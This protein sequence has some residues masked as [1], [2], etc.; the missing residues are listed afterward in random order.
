MYWIEVYTLNVLD[1][2]YCIE[3]YTIWYVLVAIYCIEMYTWYVMDAIYYKEIHTWNLPGAIYNFIFSSG[4]TYVR[5]FRKRI[6]RSNPPGSPRSSVT[7]RRRSVT[8]RRT[9]RPERSSP[10]RFADA[11]HRRTAAWIYSAIHSR[12]AFKIVRQQSDLIFCAHSKLLTRKLTTRSRA[13]ITYVYFLC[14]S[15]IYL[16][17]RIKFVSTLYRCSGGFWTMSSSGPIIK[18]I[19]GNF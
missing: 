10:T 18:Y 3:M 13:T 9:A 11:A 1:A 17:S 7:A 2:I 8:A 16:P 15:I 19:K 12:S 6:F 4:S 5:P 14:T